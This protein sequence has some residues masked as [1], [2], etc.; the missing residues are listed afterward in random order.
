[1]AH[2]ADFLRR[3]FPAGTTIGPA[4]DVD[5]FVT[6]SEAGQP[7]SLI[8][9]GSLGVPLQSGPAVDEALRVLVGADVAERLDAT[10]Q[11]LSPHLGVEIPDARFE[12][13]ESTAR[14]AA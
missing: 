10:G 12:H 11:F 5:L 3:Q 14:P 8:V 1:M 7:S 9:G 4:G 13:V 2:Q 6:P